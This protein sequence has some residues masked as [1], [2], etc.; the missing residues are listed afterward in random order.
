MLYR[1]GVRVFNDWLKEEFLDV[2]GRVVP[3]AEISILSVDDAV[4]ETVRAAEM[5]F[6]A[7]SLPSALERDRPNWNHDSWEPLWSAAEDVGM[8]LAVHVGSDAKSPDHPDNRPFRGPGRRADELRGVELQRATDG[9]HAG[10]VRR[11][12]PSSDAPA[13]D[14]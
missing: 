14:L 9:H 5:G 3:A 10:G 7:I 12:G 2:T 4:A 13:A 6:L 1:E 8:V 11:S